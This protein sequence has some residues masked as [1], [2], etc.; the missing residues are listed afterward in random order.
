MACESQSEGTVSGLCPEGGSLVAVADVVAGGGGLRLVREV[1][2]LA[3]EVGHQVHDPQ[4]FHGVAECMALGCGLSSSVCWGGGGVHVADDDSGGEHGNLAVSLRAHLDQVP[5]D[6]PSETV[7]QPSSTAHFHYGF[8]TVES[9]SWY[10]NK[11]LSSNLKT[12][13]LQP[14]KRCHTP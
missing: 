14:S 4:H 13:V 11:L 9:L 12:A 5:L 8:P 10:S 3:F 7:V 6:Y 1:G 2:W